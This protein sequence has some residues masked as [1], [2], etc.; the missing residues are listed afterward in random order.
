LMHL[1]DPRIEWD[2]QKTIF[3]VLTVILRGPTNSRSLFNQGTQ[4]LKNNCHRQNPKTNIVHTR[5][6]HHFCYLWAVYAQILPLPR[7]V[8][9]CHLTPQF[10]KM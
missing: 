8:R 4:N 1:G 5:K 6:R 2:F 7:K 10:Q 3:I 9:L